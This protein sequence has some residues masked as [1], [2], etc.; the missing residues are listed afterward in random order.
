MLEPTSRYH[1]LET[2]TFKAP[3][4]RILPYKR[5][6]F[7]P[8]GEELP[9]LV[10]VTVTAGDRLDMITARTGCVIRGKLE[11]ENLIVEPGA[12]LDGEV[13]T[14]RDADIGAAQDEPGP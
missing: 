12:S 3:D 7:L 11:A 10:E 5:R 4:G 2:A 13:K 6:R 8:K 9:L 1:S 14:V